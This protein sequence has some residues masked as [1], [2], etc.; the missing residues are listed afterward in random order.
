M[1]KNIDCSSR[2][3]TWQLTWHVYKSSPE[4]SDFSLLTSGGSRYRCLHIYTG[5]TPIYIK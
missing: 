3:P 4:G 5:K 1:A 2:A